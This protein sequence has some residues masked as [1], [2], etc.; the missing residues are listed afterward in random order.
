MTKLMTKGSTRPMQSPPNISDILQKNKLV[1]RARELSEM[2]M[3]VN[4]YLPPPLNEHCWVGN[5]D[6]GVLLLVT[7]KASAATLIRCHG[8]QVLKHINTEFG[9]KTGRLHKVRVRVSHHLRHEI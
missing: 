5:C 1:N 2:T 3:C 6:N 4:R 8:H 9:S 7:D